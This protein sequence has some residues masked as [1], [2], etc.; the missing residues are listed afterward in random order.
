MDHSF[1]DKVA[2]I[3]SLSYKEFCSLV[4][5]D[6]VKRILT[7]LK[8]DYE[9]VNS[10]LRCKTVCHNRV[11]DKC[12]LKLY[13]YSDSKIFYCYTQCQAMNI[14]SFY[15]HFYHANYDNEITYDEAF[16]ELKSLITDKDYLKQPRR[17]RQLYENRYV[18]RIS[19][20]KL[21]VY[22][23][24]ILSAFDSYLHPLWRADGI[25]EKEIE[26][27]NIRFSIYY[28]QII[29]PHYDI[30]GQLIG[31]RTRAI[32]EEDIALG[33]Y[34]PFKHNN[35]L[36]NHPLGF[37][38]YGLYEHKENIKKFRTAVIVEGEKS[39]LLEDQY[40]GDYAISVAVCGNK[41]SRAQILLLNELDV[42]E[43]VIAFDKE[44]PTWDSEKRKTYYKFLHSFCDKYQIYAHFSF[45]IDKH[46]YLQEKDSPFDRGFEIYEKLYKERIRVN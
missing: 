46:G 16:Q 10:G 15:Q 2:F 12:S 37:N 26:K 22:N 7:E 27:F 34:R 21:K 5:L 32:D 23:S 29:I 31:I 41:I 14:I 6:T 44:F 30:N 42:N 13:Y 25:S 20:P 45:I 33:K 40:Y 19:S 18:N 36:Y 38:L 9:E 35:I 39:C 17:V 4:T 3:E 24:N 28:N 11:D 8:V 1:L 43:I